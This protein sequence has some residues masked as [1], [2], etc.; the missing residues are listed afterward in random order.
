MS[1]LSDKLDDALAQPTTGG[2]A[3]RPLKSLVCVRGYR[4]VSTLAGKPQVV[5]IQPMIEET[6]WER[7]QGVKGE[8][9]E[10]LSE[11]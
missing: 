2:R 5:A 11:P 6:H 8:M 9:F 10:R 4:V 7:L 3:R 1:R